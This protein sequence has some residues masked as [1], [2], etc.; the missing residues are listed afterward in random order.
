MDLSDHA[1]R[2]APGYRRPLIRLLLGLGLGLLLLPSAR[3]LLSP[4]PGPEAALTV[5]ALGLNVE[6]GRQAF[7]AGV[8][9]FENAD[10]T[11]AQRHWA[12]F[13]RRGHAQSQFHM[14]LL[15]DVSVG[16]R[17]DA[18][19]AVLWYRLAAE[20]GL[21]EAQHKLALAYARGEGLQQDMARAVRWWLRAAR[22]GNADSQYNLGVIYTLGRD[23]IGRDP[24]K[25][26]HWWRQAAIGGD[27]MAQYNLGTLYA[28]GDAGQ[29]DLCQALHWWRQSQQNGFEQASVALRSQQGRDASR[30]C[31]VQAGGQS[32]GSF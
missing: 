12:P 3:A 5:S 17:P 30:Q 15:H 8:A 27:P 9:A 29:P 25:A 23:G 11:L 7:E 28:N 18:A 19:R 26:A 31:R 22:Q 32:P 6:L 14:G 16:I 4:E 24:H 20:Q 1:R 2:V 21:P 10:Y 13:A